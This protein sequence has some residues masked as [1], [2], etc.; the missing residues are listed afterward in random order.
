MPAYL[1]K[2]EQELADQQKAYEDQQ[3]A[4]AAAK[5]LKQLPDSERFVPPLT[6]CLVSHATRSQAILN[7]LKAN[8]EAT[9]HEFQGLSMVIDN[10]GKKHHKLELEAKL[11]QL[12]ADIKRIEQHKVI[13]VAF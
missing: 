6:P 3:A 11:A 5:S 7:G 9:L 12:E 1:T 10:I 4:D 2:R 8:W 13:Y